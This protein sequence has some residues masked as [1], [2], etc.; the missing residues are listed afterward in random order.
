[1]TA[2]NILAVDDDGL[3]LLMLENLLADGGFAPLTAASGAQALALLEREHVDLIIS[4]LIMEGMDGLELLARVK[5]RYPKVPVIVVTARGSV[6]SAV[7]AMRRGAYDYLAKPF[8]PE[9]L[10]ITLQRALDYHHVVRENE[11]ITGLLRERFTFQSIVTVN[12][13][14]KKLLELAARVAA[15]RQTTVAVYGESGSGKEVLARAIHF[16]GKGLPAGFVA[17]NCAAVPEHLLESELFG[18]VRGAFTGADRDREGKFSLARGG[19]LLLDEIGD[20]PLPLQAKLLRVLQERVFE[21]IGSNT[22]ITTDCR[23][24]VATNRNLADMVAA[25]RFRE[26]L[27]HRINVF[28]LVIPPLRERTDDIP[29]LCEHVLDQL[30]QHLGKPLPGI[31][32]KAMDAMLAHGW[33][34]NVREL[35]NCLERAAI[36]TDGELI[37]PEHLGFGTAGAPAREAS[38]GPAPD[39]VQYALALPVDQL[40]LHALTERIMAITLERCGGNKSRAAQLLR[41]DRKAFYR[42]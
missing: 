12:P 6:E 32:Q 36:L 9:V 23:V 30:R 2:P 8:N 34:G 35:R 1:M 13:A 3:S 14:M 27:Y 31:S 38:A 20:M 29:L 11:Q 22:S 7:E 17:V 15:A 4:D 33:P 28:P 24:I 37:R 18:H 16:A 10:R 40:S 25:G 19:T 41:I 26:D 42:G 5:E 21:K 39:T